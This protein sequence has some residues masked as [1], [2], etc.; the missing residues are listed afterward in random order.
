MNC[1]IKK[2]T[3]KLD[4]SIDKIFSKMGDKLNEFD[5]YNILTTTKMQKD[6]A[7][8][9][10]EY[11]I[12]LGDIYEQAGD[13]QK[14][15]ADE[16]LPN[17]S[18]MLVQ[19]LNGD[20]SSL[21]LPKE[22][23]PLYEKMRAKID[24]NA[25]ELVKLGALK[26]KSK[27]K[28][29]LKRYYAA[30]L[31]EKGL[32]G[33]IFF[34]KKF[35]KRKN[36]THDERIAMSMIED[37]SVVIPKTLAEQRTQILKA[38]VLKSIA[39][40]FAK[41]EEFEN[42]VKISNETNGGV[43]KYGALAGK[44]VPKE[45]S[46]SLKSSQLARETLGIMEKYWFPVIDHIKVNVTVKNPVTH[47][48]NIGSNVMLAGLNGDLIALGQVMYMKVKNPKK[49]KKLV[50]TANKYGLNS[51]LKDFEDIDVH[52]TDKKK[53]NVG[54][55]IVKNLYLAQGSKAGDK[56]RKLYD[57]EDKLFKVASFKRLMD[58]GV[59]EKDAFKKASEVYVDYSTPLPD[60][61]R[62]IDK[63]GLFPFMHYVYKATPATMKV[64]A[65]HPVRY[66]LLQ[67]A[68]LG[69]GASSWLDNSSSEEDLLKPIWAKNQANLFGAKEWVNVGG[70]WYMNLGR[71]IPAMKFGGIDISFDTG[72]GF[73]GG[74]VNIASGKT[75][76]G[77][78]ISGKYDES[79]IK[80]GKKILTMAENYLPPLTFGRYGQ[81]FSKKLM[82]IEQKN[83]YKEDM[84]FA[85]LGGRGVGVRRFNE[86]KELSSR[87]KEAKNLKKFKDKS[88]SRDKKENQKE[89][90]DTARKIKKAGK[91]VG[92]DLSGDDKTFN[93]KKAKFDF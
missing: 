21:K 15:L 83:Y 1:G 43:Y 5:K 22:L 58:D 91:R 27:I 60:F 20:M 26:S 3:V 41:D 6:F 86:K 70:S 32:M 90:D 65:K 75:P 56:I 88:K 73:V 63:S 35:K 55:S 2:A 87:L 44:Y 12:A 37:A 24:N 38:S 78:N 66:A 77:Y 48:Y 46:N 39:D 61:V 49:F 33:K 79:H 52:I 62:T 25:D 59:A 45:I 82:G 10:K 85:E 23:K 31:N 81:R 9:I 36:L 57:W 67:T 54:L 42:S 19:A 64:I 18:E 16:L 53:I 69:A 4:D 40:K 84:S 93:F 7:E 13:I 76:L 92:F 29:Y 28:D 17:E 71:M 80:A 74:M 14:H 50:D 34:D 47:L 30:Y 89:Y 68:L 8:S 51:S 72:F 11:Q